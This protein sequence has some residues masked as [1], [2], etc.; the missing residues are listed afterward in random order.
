MIYTTTK[1]ISAS[2]LNSKSELSII[3]A[4]QI[5]QDNLTDLMGAL[6]IDGLTTRKKYNAMWVISKNRLKFVKAPFWNADVVVESFV[7]SKSL[8]KMTIDTLIKDGDGNI[9]VCGHTELCALDCAT[10]RIKKIESVNVGDNI[11]V[12]NSPVQI[13]YA[14]FDSEIGKCIEECQVRSTNID[15]LHH[16]NNIEYLRFILNTYQEKDLHSVSEMEMLYANQAF[17]G[18][19]LQVYKT[20]TDNG[21]HVYL[22][23]GDDFVIKSEIIQK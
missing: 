1:N 2:L 22:K 18:E 6:G 9:C 17:E 3:G 11:E 10:G 8:V 12:H 4:F 7:S 19:Y 15:Y 21:Y 20:A 13:E 23:R 16:C 5:V 14:H